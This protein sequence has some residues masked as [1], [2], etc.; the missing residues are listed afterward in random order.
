MLGNRVVSDCGAHASF[1]AEVTD[2]SGFFLS[3]FLFF[4]GHVLRARMTHHSSSDINLHESSR[5]GLVFIYF[6]FK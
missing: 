4:F 6:I 2:G 5:V 1:G 3:F